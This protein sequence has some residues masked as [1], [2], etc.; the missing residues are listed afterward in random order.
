[1]AHVVKMPQLLQDAQLFLAMKTLLST[2]LLCRETNHDFTTHLHCPFGPFSF[3][4]IKESFKGYRKSNSN[5]WKQSRG[6]TV[7]L[8]VQWCICS[9]E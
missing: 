6:R 3:P 1:M 4:Q 8:V 9:S 5:H 2:T 7:L